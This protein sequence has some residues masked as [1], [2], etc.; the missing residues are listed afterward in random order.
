MPIIHADEIIKELWKDVKA[1]YP[2]F[3]QKQFEDVCRAPFRF[4][5]TQMETDTLPTIHIKGLG[6]LIVL[7]EFIRNIMQRNI[8]QLESGYIDKETFN[9]RQALCEQRL[10]MIIER[11]ND[12]KHKKNTRRRG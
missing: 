12:N 8:K 4:F 7:P 10:K 5:K 2:D 3:T 6:K 1:K 9:Q 11:E